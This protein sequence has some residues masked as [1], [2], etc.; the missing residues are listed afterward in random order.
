[1]LSSS[2]FS[3]SAQG[4]A[5]GPVL[6]V[7]RKLHL[8]KTHTT[9]TGES[10]SRPPTTYCKAA[11]G[12]NVIRHHGSSATYRVP[13][14]A[15]QVR[16]KRPCPASDTKVGRGGEG[17]R[18]VISSAAGDMRRVVRVPRKYDSHARAPN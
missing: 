8:Q 9:H 11:G 17:A 13:A 16:H 6:E 1:M 5:I 4:M 18:Q 2:V 15:V 12:T 10:P 3:S 7:R 14:E